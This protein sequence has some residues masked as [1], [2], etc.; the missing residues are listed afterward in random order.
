M[1]QMQNEILGVYSS[2]LDSYS[3]RFSLGDIAG[4]LALALA[5]SQ[6]INGIVA[7]RLRVGIRNPK[8]VIGLGLIAVASVIIANTLPFIPG[9]AIPIIGFPFTWELLACCLLVCLAIYI[10]SKAY[11]PSKYETTLGRNY[12]R[13]LALL[14]S[15]RKEDELNSYCEE[16]PKSVGMLL[17]EIRKSKDNQK[18]K[19]RSADQSVSQTILRL[20][21]DDTLCTILAT[22]HPIE[23]YEIMQ[24][25]KSFP[26]QRS[27][28]V[29]NLQKQLLTNPNSFFIKDMENPTIGLHQSIIEDF[30]GDWEYVSSVHFP[31]SSIDAFSPSLSY[32]NVSG[33]CSC[34]HAAFN[35][36]VKNGKGNN[37]TPLH[38]GLRQIIEIARVS[39]YLHTENSQLKSRD[40]FMSYIKIIDTFRDILELLANAPQEALD[41]E[42]GGKIFPAII[43]EYYDIA[44]RLQA[45]SSGIS[46]RT[47]KIWSFLFFPDNKDKEFTKAVRVNFLERFMKDIRSNLS[48]RERIYPA[49]TKILFSFY[50]LDN[51]L[52]YMKSDEESE[53][54]SE[55]FSLLIKNYSSI[56]EKESG[57]AKSLLPESMTYDPITKIISSV[58]FRSQNNLQVE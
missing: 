25:H 4:I 5:F 20:W 3:P 54:A 2:T 43:Y 17:L 51:S 10:I 14:I 38:D 31:L 47:W 45:N 42:L 35:S 34:L 41:P 48:V 18:R 53:V 49:M 56:H 24:I 33:F 1:I 26:N 21:S 52:K 23:T 58:Q 15:R 32:E 39:S 28:L 7:F 22:N 29:Y 36:Y 55:F 9:Q 44:S 6:I 8:L 37:A 46:D 16:M 12:M 40:V 50:D 57:Y 27:P 13:A 30:F 11:L 19:K